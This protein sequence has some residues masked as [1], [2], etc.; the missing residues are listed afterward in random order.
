M[1]K[2]HRV[3]PALHGERVVVSCGDC[4]DATESYLDELVRELIVNRGAGELALIGTDEAFLAECRV[5]GARY[6]VADRIHLRRAIEV[7]L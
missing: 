5:A 7:G 2:K 6:G 1:I 3:P 4:V